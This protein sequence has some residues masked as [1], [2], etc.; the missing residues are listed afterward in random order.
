MQEDGNDAS[1]IVYDEFLECVVRCAVATHDYE[2]TN[3]TDRAKYEPDASLLKSNATVPENV[4][5]PDA[6]MCRSV[7]R[8]RCSQV[9]E[10]GQLR[11]DALSLFD[12]V[13]GADELITRDE[14]AFYLSKHIP[15]DFDGSILPDESLRV[16]F[17]NISGGDG[18]VSI[19][20]FEQFLAHGSDFESQ[21]QG[22]ALAGGTP[23]FPESFKTSKVEK[24]SPF[25]AAEE[26]DSLRGAFEGF[27]D[28]Y[29]KHEFLAAVYSGAKP[30]SGK[31]K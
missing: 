25:V 31:E 27:I 2:F 28:A 11:Y 24:D 19:G 9:L 12:C 29:I 10:G 16:V 30:S 23:A 18:A 5:T 3:E 4:D 6:R 8:K 22:A 26:G 14:F 21:T 13:N 20:D 15:A 1:Q 7:F 17:D